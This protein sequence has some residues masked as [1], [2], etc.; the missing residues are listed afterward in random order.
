MSLTRDA[1]LGIACEKRRKAGK[2]A[3][4]P[5]SAIQHTR[6]ND[7]GVIA[8]KIVVAQVHLIHVWRYFNEMR[9]YRFANWS[10]L[11]GPWASNSMNSVRANRG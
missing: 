10:W 11:C 4:L 3:V 7:G 8:A 6:S 9:G 5:C 1:V 2:R